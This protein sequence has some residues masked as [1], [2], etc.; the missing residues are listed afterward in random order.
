ML[1]DPVSTLASG[2]LFQGSIYESLAAQ[3][4]LLRSPVSSQRSIH[5][6]SNHSPFVCRAHLHAWEIL[7]LVFS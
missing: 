1:Q 6:H 5:V 4:T 2:V 3:I 7:Q